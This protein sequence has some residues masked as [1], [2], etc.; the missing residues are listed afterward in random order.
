MVVMFNFDSKAVDFFFI[1]AF[2][3]SLASGQLRG[4]RRFRLVKC[5][6]FFGA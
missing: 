3:L 4:L 5:G 6:G 2:Y 1:I